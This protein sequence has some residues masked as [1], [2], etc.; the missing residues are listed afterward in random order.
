MA[1]ELLQMFQS[2]TTSDHDELVDQ[3]AFLLQ[4]DVNTAT[5]FLEASNW[6][7]ETAANNYL[8]TAPTAT[9]FGDEFGGSYGGGGGDD[10][11][12]RSA[13]AD[14]DAMD[15]DEG[16]NASAATAM[17]SEAMTAASTELQAKF[18]SDLSASQN[19]M[20]FPGMIVNMEWS[21]TNTGSEAW[22]QDTFLVFSQGDHFDAPQRIHVAADAGVSVNV[23]VC[24]RMP[25]QAGAHAGSW[26]LHAPA[27][28]FFGDPVW[29]I[30]NV[31]VS[32]DEPVLAM[33]QSAK[34]SEM[35]MHHHHHHTVLAGGSAPGNNGLDADD[36][37]DL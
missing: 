14:D 6:N 19:T 21:F 30:L 20:F 8:S 28:G 24:L 31:G 5:F 17:D 36:M 3:F 29:V 10:S 18:T 23:H 25:P 2:I 26:R 13:P 7:V 11:T 32:H 9:G 15:T 33:E 4:T 22:P 35:A 34:M 27:V 12:Q 37:M 1:D 16:A